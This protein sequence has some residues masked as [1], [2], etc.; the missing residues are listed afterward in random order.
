MRYFRV[1]KCH[2]ATHS[3]FMVRR[4]TFVSTKVPI[5]AGL[6]NS[7]ANMDASSGGGVFQDGMR[8]YRKFC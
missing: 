5:G 7:A 8:K 1:Y 2:Q 4:A 3:T 6:S